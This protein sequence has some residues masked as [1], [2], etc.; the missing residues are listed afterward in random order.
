MQSIKFATM[1]L[2]FILVCCIPPSHSS[3]AL[4]IDTNGDATFSGN[5]TVKGSIRGIGM[6]PP[7]GIIMF[8]G[9]VDKAFDANGTGRKDTHYEGWQLCNGKNG[10]PDLQDRFVAAA[11]RKYKIG[12]QGGSDVVTLTTAQ[13]PAHNHPGT[14]AVAGAHAH[15]IEGTNAKGL[16]MRTR[17]YPGQTTTAMGWGGG[18]NAD[19]GTKQWRGRVNTNTAGNHGHN[20]ST[21]LAGGGQAHENKPSFYALAFIMRLPSP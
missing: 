11:G 3:E 8:S 19:P 9:D 15:W 6:T 13:M 21:A 1:A 12:E 18:S 20:F 4:F 10:A 5:A 14:T 17:T 7:G 16:A 2:F